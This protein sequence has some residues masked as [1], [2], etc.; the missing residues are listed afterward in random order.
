MTRVCVISGAASG[1]GRATLRLFCSRGYACLGIDH[2]AAANER[3]L[4]ELDDSA[5][6]RVRLLE[7]DLLADDHVDLDAI[8]AL[9]GEKIELTV[10]NNVGGSRARSP[11]EPDTWDNFAD[12]LAFNLKPVHTLTQACLGVMRDNEYGRIVNVA[13]V[14]A[15]KPLPIVDPAY[16]AAKAA[17][18]A[19]SRQLAL[20][21]AG[22]GVLVNAVCPGIIATDRIVQR[23]AGRSDDV[24]R[25]LARDI[26]LRRLGRPEEVAEA[27]YFLGSTSTYATGSI[28]DINGGM[29]TP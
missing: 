5:R 15:R 2:D 4:S 6:G 19:L 23:W 29:Y 13:S 16:A 10:V 18:L 14:A 9:G 1:I 20:E 25:E 17:L 22:D 21:L 28:L 8:E 11:R 26:A 7:I 3:L 27:I 12:V 24:N